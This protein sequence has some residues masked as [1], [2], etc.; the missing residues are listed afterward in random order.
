MLY[1]T[2]SLHYAQAH[3]ANLQIGLLYTSNLKLREQKFLIY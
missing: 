1:G 2:H 3:P